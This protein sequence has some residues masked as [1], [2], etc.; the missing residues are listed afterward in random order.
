MG[1]GAAVVPSSHLCSAAEVVIVN[2]FNGLE[3]DDAL[4]LRLMLICSREGTGIDHGAAGDDTGR[5]VGRGTG[6]HRDSPT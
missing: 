1:I 3:V 6:Q 4:Q 2:L 5:D